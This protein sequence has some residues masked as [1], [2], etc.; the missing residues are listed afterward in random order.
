MSKFSKSLRVVWLLGASILLIL[1][2][3]SLVEYELV[4]DLL[5]HWIEQLKARK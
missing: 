3:G 1:L 2:I 4:A 5:L